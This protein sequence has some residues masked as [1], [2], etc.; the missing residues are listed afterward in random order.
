MKILRSLLPILTLLLLAGCAPKQQELNT[1]MH[2]TGL[3]PPTEAKFCRFDGDV[4]IRITEEK[5]GEKSVDLDLQ[6]KFFAYI[7]FQHENNTYALIHEEENLPYYCVQASVYCGNM[8]PSLSTTLTLAVDLEKEYMIILYDL[9]PDLYYVAASDPNVEPDVILQHFEKIV[10]LELPATQ[11]EVDF[12]LHASVVTVD[13]KIKEKMDVS[14]VNET[15]YESGNRYVAMSI[16]TPGTFRYQYEIPT[17]EIPM[18]IGPTQP[19]APSYYVWHGY[20]YDRESG[21]YCLG[22]YAY[23]P[24]EQYLIM[25]WNDDKQEYLIASWTPQPPQKILT[26][27]QEFIDQYSYED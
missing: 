22:I 20:S 9:L 14:I 25:S 13:G 16:L 17:D 4:Q 21:E 11:S 8:R 2:F 19:G 12:D 23:C 24:A 5:S 27:F 26:Y 10:A 18:D 3:Y 1:A 15:I 7:D 6:E